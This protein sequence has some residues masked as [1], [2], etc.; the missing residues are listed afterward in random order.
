MVPAQAEFGRHLDVIFLLDK[1]GKKSRD[2]WK[3]VWNQT[4]AKYMPSSHNVYHERKSYAQ[5]H[6]NET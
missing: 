6:K 4:L 2:T 5:V 1:Y 3:A